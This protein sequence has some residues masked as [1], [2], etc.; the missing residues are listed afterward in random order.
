MDRKHKTSQITQ[1][2]Q[3]KYK[4]Q[5]VHVINRRGCGRWG[6]GGGG[7]LPIRLVRFTFSF[8]MSF[9]RT[10]PPYLGM[11]ST[12]NNSMSL[13]FLPLF[14]TASPMLTLASQHRAPLLSKGKLK[15]T[16]AI[17][18]RKPPQKIILRYVREFMRQGQQSVQACKAP[19]KQ[20]KKSIGTMR[21]RYNTYCTD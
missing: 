10:N 5:T 20:T 18:H 6:G 1:T 4:L 9:L 3:N 7:G 15:C 12:C 17:I 2:S 13:R 16:A 19:T 21:L 11:A 8:S 14:V